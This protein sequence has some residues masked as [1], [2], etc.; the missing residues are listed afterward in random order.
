MASYRQRSVVPL[1][2]TLSAAV[3]LL[4]LMRAADSGQSGLDSVQGF[5]ISVGALAALSIN[6]I[7]GATAIASGRTAAWWPTLLSLIGLGAWLYMTLQKT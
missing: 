6:T 2:L 7:L 1:W 4:F 3:L 5:A